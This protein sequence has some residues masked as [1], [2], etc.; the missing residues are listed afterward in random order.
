VELCRNR[1]TYQEAF[2]SRANAALTPRARHRLARLIVEGGRPGT[3]AA[4]LFMVSPITARKG[5]AR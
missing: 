3:T 4:K 1:F 2:V 5:A